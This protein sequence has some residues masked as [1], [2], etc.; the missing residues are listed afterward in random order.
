[1]KDEHDNLRKKTAGIVYVKIKLKDFSESSKRY[2]KEA[3]LDK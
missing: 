3:L 2:L 1:M